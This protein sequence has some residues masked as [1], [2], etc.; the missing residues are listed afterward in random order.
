MQFLLFG[1]QLKRND[2]DLVTAIYHT[3]VRQRFDGVLFWWQSFSSSSP[4]LF[5]TTCPAKYTAADT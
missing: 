3:L 2:Q 5:V 1:G 4:V